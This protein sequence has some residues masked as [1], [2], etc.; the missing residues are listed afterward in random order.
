MKQ[1]KRSKGSLG[2]SLPKDARDTYDFDVDDEV[3]DDPDKGEEV[4][5][6]RR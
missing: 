4:R 5:L 3:N 6:D 1:H 2:A